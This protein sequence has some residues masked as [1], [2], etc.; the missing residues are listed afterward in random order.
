MMVPWTKAMSPITDTF[1]DKYAFDLTMLD[2]NNNNNKHTPSRPDWASVA[3]NRGWCSSSK[4]A[5][6]TRPQARA[7]AAPRHG[8]PVGGCGPGGRT[9]EILP[10][11]A[12]VDIPPHSIDSSAMW[13]R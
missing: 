4:E 12:D 7:A 6:H 9:D 2:Y 3:L 11:N 13:Y 10:I 8:H 1:T 5:H